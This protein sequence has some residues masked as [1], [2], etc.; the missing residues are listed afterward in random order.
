[1]VE[2]LFEGGFVDAQ[3]QGD[4]AEEAAAVGRGLDDLAGAVVADAA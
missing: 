2:G 1:M 4:F 3:L